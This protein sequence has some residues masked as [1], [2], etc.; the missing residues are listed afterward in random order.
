MT[1]KLSR[2]LPAEWEEQDAVL[3]AWPHE[4]TD[5]AAQ[6]E[7]AQQNFCNII[8]AISRV[9]KVLLI[10][11]DIEKVLLQLKAAAINLAQVRLYELPCNDTWARDFGPLTVRTDHGPRLL[12]FTFNGWGNKF[13]ADLDNR[14]TTKLAAAGAFGETMFSSIELVLEGGSLESDGLGTLL[15]TSDCLLEKNR[16]PHLSQSQIEEE[17]KLQFGASQVLWLDHGALRGDD[18]DSH[19]DTLARFAPNQTILFQGCNDPTDEHYQELSAMRKQLSNFLTLC[20]KGYRLLELPWPQA[21]YDSNKNRLPATYANFLII[22]GAVLVPTYN[23]PAD[24]V[25]LNIIARAFPH[26]EIIPIDCRTLIEQHGSLH[27]V[28]MQLPKGVLP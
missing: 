5:W 13:S 18:T 6:R 22:N 20:G 10:V 1:D 3:L 4:G 27:C 15:T 26:R 11:P 25:A 28:T 16:N 21:R 14:L 2:I 17:L 24:P 12:D 23:D 7:R 9:E 19:I 8:R